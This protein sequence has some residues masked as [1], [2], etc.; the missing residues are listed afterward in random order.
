MQQVED[1]TSIL[2]NKTNMLSLDQIITILVH[3][4]YHLG[5]IKKLKRNVPKKQKR[6]F[7][8][9]ARTALSV[10]T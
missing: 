6:R 4:L 2:A 5:A 3:G 9:T 10:P 8:L 7:Q 1:T